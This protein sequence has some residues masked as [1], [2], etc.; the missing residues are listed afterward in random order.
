MHRHYIRH[1]VLHHAC[2]WLQKMAYNLLLHHQQLQMASPCEAQKVAQK[3]FR[4]VK[5]G[6]YNYIDS[7][8]GYNLYLYT[9]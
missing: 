5:H 1:F 7:S 4:L 6:I 8:W 2:M 3:L 9:L